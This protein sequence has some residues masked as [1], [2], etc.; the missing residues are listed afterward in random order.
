M[1]QI[2]D[3]LSNDEDEDEDYINHLKVYFRDYEDILNRKKGRK[4]RH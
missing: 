2:L 1:N 3:Q 4:P